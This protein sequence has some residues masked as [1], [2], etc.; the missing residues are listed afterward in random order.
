MNARRT[1]AVLLVAGMVC[2][3]GAAL[4]LVTASAEAEAGSGLGSFSLSAN[5]PVMQVR[6][7][8]A[9][10]Q[11][12][13]QTAG[14]AGCEGVIN[15]TVSRLTNGPVG[16]ALSSVTWPGTLAG[17]LGTLL[18]TLGGSQVPPQ[19]V[20]LNSPIRAEARTGGTNPVITD[21]P[22]APAPTIAHMKAEALATKVT[23]EAALGGVQQAGVGTLGASSSRTSTVLTGPAEAKST[24]HSEV[25]NITLGSVLNIGGVVSDATATTDGK[26][27]KASGHTIVTG[28]TVAGIPVSIDENGITVDAQ[29]V[30]FPKAATDAVN[31][32]LAGAGITVALSEAHGTPVG[33]SVTYDAGALVVLW[34]MQ[35]GTALSV[36]LG[37][38][39]V[40]VTA[41]PGLGCLF[42]CTPGGTTG[43]TTGTG[44]VG[45]TGGTS[46]PGTLDP[47]TLPGTGVVPP[48]GPGPV[49]LEP[50]AQAFTGRMP[51][52]LSPW[53]GALAALGSVL[54]MAGLRRLPDRVLVASSAAC[55][56]GVI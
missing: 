10:H 28:A 30:P 41:A 56:N 23:A 4:P 32:A 24:A 43:G 55:P 13:A 20:A 31:S 35:E 2:L 50:Q 22:P 54:V 49:T 45:T 27:A 21:Y 3:A 38:A 6:F 26:T 33:P 16:Y 14:T 15:E 51:H 53:L 5:A 11:C 34:K 52:G 48:T 46:V 9:A 47:G 44:V 37:G 19:A 40:A 8:D 12:S 17:N 36:T 1:G 42:N 39:Q 25:Q 29:N 18:L 7:D